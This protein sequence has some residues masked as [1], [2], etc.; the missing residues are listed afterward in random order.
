MYSLAKQDEIGASSHRV[1]LLGGEVLLDLTPE[2][3]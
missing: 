3:G 2:L 1:R